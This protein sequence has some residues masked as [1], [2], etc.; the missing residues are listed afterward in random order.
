MVDTFYGYQGTTMLHHLIK[1]NDPSLLQR[2]FG[3][4]QANNLY[5]MTFMGKSPLTYAYENKKLQHLNI[6]LGKFN[7]FPESIIASD[8]DLLT[9][10]DC[11][12]SAGKQLILNL[13]TVPQFYKCAL[14][15]QVDSKQQI[16]LVPFENNMIGQPLCN[17]IVN[18]FQEKPGGEDIVLQICSSIFEFDFERGSPASLNF[19]QKYS[20][21]S[22]EEVVRSNLR[23]IIAYKYKECLVF[24]KLTG[25]RNYFDSI[26]NYTDTIAFIFLYIG[27]I[28]SLSEEN[29]IT[30]FCLLL[31]GMSH[32]RIFSSLR[33]FINM[34]IE[35]IK[36]MAS[37][38][39][40]LV[41]WIVGFSLM[42]YLFSFE[43]EYG[44]EDSFDIDASSLNFLDSLQFTYKLSFGDFDT[45][46][47]TVQQWILFIIS[48]FFI[49]L[50]L[51]NLIIAVMGD[52]YDRVQTSAASVDLKEQAK[53]VLEVEGLLNFKNKGQQVNLKRLLICHDAE[54]GENAPE[55]MM[56]EGKIKILT[57]MIQ[58]VDEKVQGSLNMKQ[59]LFN[60]VDEV[61]SMV[62]SIKMK[63]DLK[64]P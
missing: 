62:K 14:P 41:Y 11:Q 63:L 28:M 44:R 36:D 52:T 56:W 12:L 13:F 9:L 43:K 49:P 35:I 59:D 21:E 48:T 7:N 38:S 45:E 32:F 6:I 46:E 19:L 22:S 15:F 3:D 25:L 34:I 24:L 50:V 4:A 58:K 5:H 26:W 51:F 55:Q 57:K 17:Q 20:K 54:L 1:N 37:F 31:R 33:Y 60:A 61:K 23:F 8:E 42:F 53:L 27:I 29:N 10:M 30:V 64:S 39:I 47:F 16:V 2:F 18:M 40:I